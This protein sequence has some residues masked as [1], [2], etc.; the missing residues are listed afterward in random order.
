[1]SKQEHITPEVSQL[2][3]PL[4][5]HGANERRQQALADMIDRME[6]AEQQPGHRTVSLGRWLGAATAVAACVAALVWVN[7]DVADS[8]VATPAPVTIS[9]RRTV[10]MAS[11][12]VMTISIK[13]PARAA[14]N[15]AAAQVAPATVVE[16]TAEEAVTTVAT[17]EP[18]TADVETTEVL[19]ADV[20]TAR[21]V[22]QSNNLVCQSDCHQAY[23]LMDSQSSMEDPFA[24]SSRR[25]ARQEPLLV[26]SL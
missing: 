12:P 10:A 4:A 21:R 18:T 19:A 6:A 8:L 15:V 7:H 11:T 17:L 20:K 14:E 25:Q 24:L 16:Q 5:E 9:P 22:I 3:N 26:A 1:M 2:L 23:P 13:Q